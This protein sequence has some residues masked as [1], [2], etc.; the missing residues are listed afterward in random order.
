M[1]NSIAARYGKFRSFFRPAI[2]LISYTG[3]GNRL[4]EEKNFDV[5]LSHYNEELSIAKE[6]QSFIRLAFDRN[7][8]VFRSSDNASIPTGADQYG[9]IL[10]ALRT[11]KVVIVLLSSYSWNRPWINFEVGFAAAQR[12]A[13]FTVLIR[14]TKQDEI[15]TPLSQLQ[16]RPLD[17][18]VVSEILRAIKEQTARAVS[19]VDPGAFIDQ[20]RRTESRMPDIILRLNPVVSV[21]PDGRRDLKFELL[22][23][24]SRPI[25][26]DRIEA[27]IP[28]EILRPGAQSGSAAGHLEINTEQR[29]G[30]WFFRKIRLANPNPPGEDGRYFGYQ[31]LHPRLFPADQPVLLSEPK[32]EILKDAQIRYPEARISFRLFT[33]EHAGESQQ[34]RL[35]DLTERNDGGC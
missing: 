16:L 13:L 9:A 31:P 26:I 23:Q 33:R 17:V 7:V 2:R 22:Y 27:E 19:N 15:G 35:A 32:F 21:H 34:A 18:G 14:G 12:A 6:L 30:E 8:S 5:S 29:N 4:T 1:D 20:I 3:E 28:Q 25:D 24:G 10:C 11:A